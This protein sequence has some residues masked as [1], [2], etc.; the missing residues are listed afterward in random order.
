MS[1]PHSSPSPQR[2]A[3]LGFF[4]SLLIH[5]AGA[6]PNAFSK[7]PPSETSDFVKLGMTV[8]V[9]FGLALVAGT[10]TLYSLQDP[11]GKS[12]GKAGAIGVLWALVVLVIDVA[13]MSQ[14]VKEVPDELDSDLRPLVSHEK[15]SRKGNRRNNIV[16]LL[17]ITIAATLGFLM[18]HC[19]VLYAFKTR[20]EQQVNANR[21]PRINAINKQ[22]EKIDQLNASM[23]EAIK[24]KN[25]L[26]PAKFLL[27]YGKLGGQLAPTASPATQASDTG[28]AS[29]VAKLN[30]DIEALQRAHDSKWAPFD[31]NKQ[32]ALDDLDK[33][34]RDVTQAELMLDY[35]KAGRRTDTF[36]YL[37]EDFAKLGVGGT[38]GIEGQGTR[39]TRI[40]ALIDAS[41]SKIARSRA[42][43]EALAA[44]QQIDKKKMEALVAA[45]QADIQRL[46]STMTNVALAGAGAADVLAAKSRPLLD[47]Q[48]ENTK[49]E[50]AKL[51]AERD[52]TLGALR[53]GRSDVLEQTSALHDMMQGKGDETQGG[54]HQLAMIG[55]VL[56]VMA[57]FILIDL[58]P[59]MMKLTREPGLYERLRKHEKNS[60]NREFAQASI[61]DE[62]HSHP[63]PATT[64]NVRTNHVPPHRRPR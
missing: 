55:M 22:Y 12:M 24:V 47:Q 16:A 23:A 10:F 40:R 20:V 19:M 50:I 41:K 53:S 3:P 37:T 39:Y 46:E 7:L 44:Q 45:K 35:E 5:L 54:G 27:E 43:V 63:R 13:V 49:S 31:K 51:T 48:I 33:L 62:E 29:N 17:R 11:D 1:P 64:T 59:L 42:E 15:P 2:D 52:N 57:C 6:D 25:E 61:R 9:P 8:L 21:V 18:S 38:S 58:T 26:D 56:L 4:R 14:L 60:Y 32:A 34:Q 36:Q 28:L 30:T